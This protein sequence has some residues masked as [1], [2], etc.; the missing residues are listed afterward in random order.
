[1]HS[2]VTWF[3]LVVTPQFLSL[4]IWCT[5][6]QSLILLVK[7]SD[8][9]GPKNLWLEAS[10]QTDIIALINSWNIILRSKP[11]GSLKKSSGCCGNFQVCHLFISRYLGK[12][13][14]LVDSIVTNSLRGSLFDAW[15]FVRCTS[16]A[17]GVIMTLNSCVEFLMF[18]TSSWH[19]MNIFCLFVSC[20]FFKW[21]FQA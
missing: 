16:L 17:L 10:L 2:S 11:G 9:L 6:L 15:W 3:L 12:G 14:W 4:K 19:Q 7:L 1:M 8:S 21:I 18:K 20:L 5:C 13:L